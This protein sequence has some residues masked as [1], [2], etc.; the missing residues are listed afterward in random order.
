MI[1]MSD[2]DFPTIIFEITTERDFL[3]PHKITT[4][5]DLH[6]QNKK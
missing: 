2:H 3:C 6:K 4:E 5:S 1:T